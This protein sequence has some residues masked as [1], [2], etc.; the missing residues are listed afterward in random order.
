MLEVEAVLWPCQARWKESSKAVATS[1][2]NLAVGKFRKVGQVQFGEARVLPSDAL[3]LGLGMERRES[4]L[5][6]K[7][8]CFCNA[9]L[10]GP[11]TLNVHSNSLTLDLS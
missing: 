2:I 1:L 11:L 3:K 7:S 8:A 6:S 9:R 5:L 10:A 4:S